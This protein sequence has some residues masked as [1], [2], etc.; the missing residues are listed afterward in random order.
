MTGGT[1]L[2][3][4]RKLQ[5]P[6]DVLCDGLG[7]YRNQSNDWY[8]Y[9]R[10]GSTLTKSPRMHAEF[11]IRSTSF[12]HQKLENFPRRV[13]EFREN[14]NKDNRKCNKILL[15]L[16]VY[17]NI[18]PADISCAPHG[19][20]NTQRPFTRTKFSVRD[21]IREQVG[22]TVHGKIYENLFGEAGGLMACTGEVDYPR[23]MKRIYNVNAEKNQTREKDEL[24][25]LIIQ[26]EDLSSPI[27]NI[28]Q[29]RVCSLSVTLATD[30]QLQLLESLCG[31]SF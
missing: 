10:V 22:K 19:N 15:A 30:F 18:W 20:S 4:M 11:E 7:S 2:V 21:R 13:V 25:E 9:T 12:K 8:Y 3:D 14:T 29:S 16:V 31:Q 5:N 28:H 17:K 27:L 24:T 6:K 26:K 23:D 1:F